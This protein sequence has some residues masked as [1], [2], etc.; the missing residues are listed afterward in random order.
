MQ[1]WKELVVVMAILLVLFATG[2]S[3]LKT[4]GGAWEQAVCQRNLYGIYQAG[5]A[6]QAD[7]D[8][9]FQPVIVR[10]KPQWTYWYRFVLPYVSD[11]VI[12][13]CPAHSRAKKILERDPGVADLVPP[14]FDPGSAT[15]GMNYAL[16]SSGDV[17]ANPRP[18]NINA[19]ADLAYTIYFGDCKMPNPSLR[20]TK[21]CWHED[22]APVHN[23]KSN[24]VFLDGHVEQMNHENLGLMHAFD[25][26]KKD[27]KRWS[28]WKTTPAKD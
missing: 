25:G 6:Y 27:P 9:A 13:Y 8:G 5:I 20:P 28:N 14:V 24:F 10:S 7:H 22:Y 2:A 4:A 3:Q 21:W 17:K 19:I 11:P 23:E 1:N 16:S 18:T 26:W 12:F 15:Y